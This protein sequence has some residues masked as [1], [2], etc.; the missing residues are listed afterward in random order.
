LHTKRFYAAISP[1]KTLHAGITLHSC[2]I[3]ISVLCVVPWKKL[4]PSMTLAKQHKTPPLLRRNGVSVFSSW[5]P[6][7]LGFTNHNGISRQTIIKLAFVK[8]SKNNTVMAR[9]QTICYKRP[10][11]GEV[12]DRTLCQVREVSTTAR[13][14]IRYDIMTGPVCKQHIGENSK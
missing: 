5:H 8:D 14:L 2:I 3:K 7:T 13:I 1:H 10:Q 12:P 9:M 4:G 6:L 11:T